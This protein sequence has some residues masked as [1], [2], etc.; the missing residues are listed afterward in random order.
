VLPTEK[1]PLWAA[2]WIAAGYDGEALIYL[3]GLHGDDP[4]EVH[5]ALPDALRYC[6]VEMPDRGTGRARSHSLISP[7][8]RWPSAT[9]SG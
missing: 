9:S 5:D 3:A 6:G 7:A 1:V 2:Y 8:R 4:C